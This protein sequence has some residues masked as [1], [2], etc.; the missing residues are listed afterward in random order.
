[1]NKTQRKQGTEEEHEG[2][3]SEMFMRYVRTK[4]LFQE[5]LRRGA[6]D[7]FVHIPQKKIERNYF[8]W[9]EYDRT[10]ELKKLVIEYSEISGYAERTAKLHIGQALKTGIIQKDEKGN[11]SLYSIFSNEDPF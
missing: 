3:A 9:P 7:G 11:Y 2:E 8:T 5:R 6:L 1:M 4:A 10:T